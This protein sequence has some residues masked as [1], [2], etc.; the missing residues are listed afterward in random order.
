M[1]GTEQYV[2]AVAKCASILLTVCGRRVDSDAFHFTPQELPRVARAWDRVARTST[3]ASRKGQTIYKRVIKDTDN[4][5]LPKDDDEPHRVLKR[6]CVDI[7]PAI[8]AQINKQRH[9]APTLSEQAPATRKRMLSRLLS[10]VLQRLISGPGKSATRRSTRLASRKSHSPQK[11]QSPRKASPTKKPD[12]RSLFPISSPIKRRRTNRRSLPAS[13]FSVVMPKSRRSLPLF[14]GLIDFSRRREEKAGEQ[15]ESSEDV[16]SPLRQ[17]LDEDTAQI[18]EELDS[19]GQYPEEDLDDSTDS[20]QSELLLDELERNEQKEREGAPVSSVS[21]EVELRR[22]SQQ[23]SSPDN[24]D[25]TPHPAE[26]LVD[27]EISPTEQNIIITHNLDRLED[28]IPTYDLRDG[29]PLPDFFEELSEITEREA[30]QNSP[31]DTSQEQ[32]ESAQDTQD[33]DSLDASLLDSPSPRKHRSIFRNLLAQSDEVGQVKSETKRN[34]NGRMSDDTTML[35]DFVKKAQSKKAAESEAFFMTEVDEITQPVFN[36]TISPRKPLASVTTN[37]PSPPSPARPSTPP[38]KDASDPQ[39]ANDESDE[40]AASVTTSRRSAPTPHPRTRKVQ[41]TP[42][43]QLHRRLDGTN[44]TV[45]QGR[46]AV[47]LAMLTRTNTRRNKGQARMPKMMLEL[48]DNK[49]LSPIKERTTKLDDNKRKMVDWD[50]RLVYFQEEAEKA[51]K[52]KGAAKKKK[53]KNVEKKDEGAEEEEAGKDKPM[54]A[55]AKSIKVKRIQGLG[56]INGTPV[57][58]KVWTRKAKMVLEAE[59]SNG[60][61]AKSGDHKVEE[62]PK[63]PSTRLPTPRKATRASSRRNAVA[64]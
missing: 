54:K 44:P 5:N 21:L 52:E 57:A 17:D 8:P 43:I 11:L 19:A 28:N 36:F 46:A 42:S 60:E 14:P 62:A 12:H 39:D 61:E 51:R 27:K 49:E 16:T 32:I 45:L 47:E 33:L 23:L 50:E 63:V 2:P 1:E 9:Y 48:L 56:V 6:Q 18:T 64:T 10:R 25:F 3:T 38:L 24:D 29:S 4:R 13:S 40:L 53:K 55:E 41:G 58:K 15:A 31:K 7:L 30:L 34:S 22:I 26:E 59:K 37:S 20:V 35:M